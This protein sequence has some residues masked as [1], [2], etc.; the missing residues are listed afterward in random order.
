MFSKW[1]TYTNAKAKMESDKKD[2]HVRYW[3]DTCQA[4]VK[5]FFAAAIWYLLLTGATFKQYH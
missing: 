5:A 2:G 1:A 3:R 4:E